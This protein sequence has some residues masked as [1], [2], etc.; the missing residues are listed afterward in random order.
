MTRT[1]RMIRSGTFNVPPSL[2][3]V[4]QCGPA[5]GTTYTY[6]VT[7]E[8]SSFHGDS[9]GFLIDNAAVRVWFESRYREGE[10]LT[11]SCEQ[12]AREC[13]EYFWEL[14]NNAEPAVR[15]NLRAFLAPLDLTDRLSFLDRVNCRIGSSSA[16][17]FDHE[18]RR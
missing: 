9:H 7:L 5:G 6:E 18:I 4:D 16:T 13:A 1:L 17:L 14:F 11:G 12:M 3:P 10:A 15:L 8:T 2:L